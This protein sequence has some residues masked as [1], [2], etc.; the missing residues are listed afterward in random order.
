MATKTTSVKGYLAA[1]SKERGSVLAT[2]RKVILE[3]LPRGFEEGILYGM[4][5]YYVP[6]ARHPDTYNGQ[7]LLF[8]ALASHKSTM[9]LYLMNV[10]SDP[11]LTRWFEEQFEKS[12]KKLRMGKSC[13]N[14]DSL[15]DLP[16]DVIGEA[17]GRTSLESFIESY[18]NSRKQRR[19][20]KGRKNSPPEKRRAKSAEP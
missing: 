3:H 19:T 8:A 16:L 12:K 13:V 9:S 10:Y 20:R 14:F 15:E 11:K 2:V 17:I 5:A 4:I 18:E 1:L 7:P 6:L